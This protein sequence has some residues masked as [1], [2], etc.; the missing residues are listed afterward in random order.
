MPVIAVIAIDRRAERAYF[1]SFGSSGFKTSVLHANNRTIFPQEVENSK[2]CSSVVAA[3]ARERD[4][5]SHAHSRL[6]TSSGGARFY[7]S[8]C[9][10]HKNSENVATFSEF[11]GREEKPSPPHPC[12]EC[13]PT[14]DRLS[15][16]GR[17]LRAHSRTEMSVTSA[18]ADYA[19]RPE[20][21]KNALAFLRI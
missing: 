4:F 9:G 19:S 11:L 2:P 13:F 5:S 7:P 8:G 12:S 17:C 15:E 6:V 20:I 3:Y 10:G 16:A 1:S 21:R 14:P 18:G